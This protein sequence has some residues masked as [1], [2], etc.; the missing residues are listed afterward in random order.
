M[1][2][3]GIIPK[4]RPGS[5][6]ADPPPA[7]VPVRRSVASPTLRFADSS[8]GGAAHIVSV[9]HP[10]EPLVLH[11]GPAS[12]P[13]VLHIDKDSAAALALSVLLMPEARVTHV[14]TLAAAREQ[15]KTHIFSAVV[16]DPTLPDGDAVELLPALTAI[17]LLVYSASQPAWRTRSGLFLPK[18]WTSPRL[19]WTTISQMLGLPTPTS[20]GD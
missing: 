17:P 11:Q 15:L 4:C 14:P 16:I 19:L 5:H 12:A 6:R 18:P 10:L 13:H 20:A 1:K 2:A 7:H 9:I 3:T 8:D